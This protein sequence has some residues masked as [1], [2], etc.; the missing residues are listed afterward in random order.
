MVFPSEAQARVDFSTSGGRTARRL[1]QQARAA[2][3][4]EASIDSC[5]R[6]AAGERLKILRMRYGYTLTSGLFDDGLCQRVFGVG[7]DGGG[8]GKQCG[9]RRAGSGR[10]CGDGGRAAGERSG[11]IED[12]DVQVAGTFQRQ[13]VLHQE[14]VLRAERGGDGNHQRN[15]E[16]QSVGAG[17]DQDGCGADQRMLLVAG[18]PPIGERHRARRD[19]DV[20][21]D[22]GGTVGESLRAGGRVP[23][24][25][26]PAA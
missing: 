24:R 4:H 17:N 2:D 3:H 8:S 25:R 7:L 1:G 15:G 6:A 12:D 5:L 22:R 23:A 18:E 9:Y 19:G 21:Q 26:Q 13:A 20:K 10:Y 16:A 11:L 14:S